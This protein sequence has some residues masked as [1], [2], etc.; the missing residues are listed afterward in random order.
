VKRPRGVSD[1]VLQTLWRA[2]VRKEWGGLCAFLPAEYPG[3]D[4]QEVCAGPLE[5]HHII[6]R[7][8]PHLKYVPS[9]GILLCKR[10]HD[11]VGEFPSKWHRVSEL[12]GADKIEWLEAQAR[13]RFPDFL[14]E[15][16]QTRSEWL[17]TTKAYLKA[18][19]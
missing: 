2:V 14:I 9:N 12:V 8:R 16:G 10:H 19:L 11:M 7:R 6:K 4:S 1:T 5:C 3:A 15:Q 18:L 13:K 17:Q